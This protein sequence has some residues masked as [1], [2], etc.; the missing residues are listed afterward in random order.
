MF[1]LIL[2]DNFVIKGKVQT[3][4]IDTLRDF[5]ELLVGFL[6]FAVLLLVAFNFFYT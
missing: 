2:F 4:L 3:V 5:R 6:A 1:H